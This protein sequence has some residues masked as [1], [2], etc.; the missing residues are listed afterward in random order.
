M[1]VKY[2]MNTKVI[3]EASNATIATCIETMKRKNIGFLV[4]KNEENEVCGVV[5]D[6]DISIGLLRYNIWDSIIKLCKKNLIFIEEEKSLLE[7][8]DTCAYYQV[9]RLVVLNSSH[10]IVG[11]LSI[12]DLL[13]I[14]NV[15][16]YVTDC[17][18]EI[19]KSDIYSSYE[20][21]FDTNLRN[22][23]SNH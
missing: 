21:E 12:F 7:A 14:P 6:R 8:A 15:K 2:V 4:I 11:V 13:A 9:M 23:S 20:L 22:L 19:K 18:L 17:I 1:Q 5:T 3:Y 10:H 16:D